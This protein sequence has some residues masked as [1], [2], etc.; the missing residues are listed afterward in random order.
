M[1]GDTAFYRL[2][3]GSPC[4]CSGFR[5]F[6][7][8][9]QSAPLLLR[10]PNLSLCPRG[11][12]DCRC[13]C[14]CRRQFPSYFNESERCPRFRCVCK[15][16]T[17]SLNSYF[18][19]QSPGRSMLGAELQSRAASSAAST[20]YAPPAHA[21]AHRQCRHRPA[22]THRLVPSAALLASSSGRAGATA[23]V[24]HHDS[25]LTSAAAPPFAGATL[26]SVAARRRGMAV[27]HWLMR[28]PLVFVD[29]L[30]ASRPSACMWPCC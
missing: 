22:A 10:C 2:P 7:R 3:D 20:S 1:H 11:A 8:F 23:A 16:L 26:D 15:P 9:P 25:R 12:A 5:T 29:I 30:L 13:I 24:Q 28:R 18:L 21:S 6:S 27:V 19:T 4:S 14:C 17:R